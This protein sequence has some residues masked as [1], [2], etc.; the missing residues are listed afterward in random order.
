MIKIIVDSSSA[1]ETEIAELN[2]IIPFG[3]MQFHFDKNNIEVNFITK[4]DAKIIM[5]NMGTKVFLKSNQEQS[6]QKIN[7]EACKPTHDFDEDKLKSTLSRIW[8]HIECNFDKK[9][10]KVIVIGA[11]AQFYMSYSLDDSQNERLMDG[12]NI[13]CG[14][15]SYSNFTL[16]TLDI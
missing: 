14:V 15:D 16:I 11:D 3:E 8:E 4:E 13:I 9:V 6:Q 10:E 12:F 7:L 2:K 5:D 1:T